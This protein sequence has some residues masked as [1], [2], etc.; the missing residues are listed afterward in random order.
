MKL[1]QEQLGKLAGVT[2]HTIMAIEAGKYDPSL[3]LASGSRELSAKM[4]KMSSSLTAS[5][6]LHNRQSMPAAT[7]RRLTERTRRYHSRGR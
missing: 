2:R 4:S 6:L 7:L 3:L 1:T 5:N